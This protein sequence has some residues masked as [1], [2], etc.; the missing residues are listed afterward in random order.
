M[1]RPY[2]DIVDTSY[3]LVDPD[4]KKFSEAFA[5]QVRVEYQEIFGASED[6]TK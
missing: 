5:H 6:L 3:I 4:L 1:A 2:E